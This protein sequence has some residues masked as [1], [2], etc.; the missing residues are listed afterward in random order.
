MGPKSTV[1]RRSFLG[2][3][4]SVSTRISI[5]VAF[6]AVLP[7]L[8]IGGGSLFIARYS[9]EN[10]AFS[11]I[12]DALE[13][14]HAIMKEYRSLVDLG[15]MSEQRALSFIRRL[16]LGDLVEFSIDA[17]DPAEAEAFFAELA[18]YRPAGS[19]VP[20]GIPERFS[21]RVD[22]GRA[23]LSDFLPVLHVKQGFEAMDLRAQA[24]LVNGPRAL[25]L[26][27]DLASAAVRI[28]NSGYVF[29][30]SRGRDPSLGGIYELFHPTLTMVDI[31]TVTN[32]RG[33]LVGLNISRLAGRRDSK[34]PEPYLRY[35]YLWYNQGDPGERKKITL[36]RDFEPWDLVLAAGLYEDEY[37]APLRSILTFMAAGLVL[38]GI[39]FFLLA[40]AFG[41]TLVGRR[42]EELGAAFA[43]ADAGAL[44]EFPVDWQDEFGAIARAA[45]HMARAI[46]EREAAL[47]QAQKREIAGAIAAGMAHDMNNALGGVL[48]SA[49]LLSAELEGDPDPA[50]LRTAADGVEK[51]A[52]A[53]AAQLRSMLDF[54][55]APEGDLLPLELGPVIDE[56]LAMARR[57]SPSEV[58][59]RWLTASGPAVIRG[60]RV[61][62]I[63]VF[64]NAFL[65]ARDAVTTMRRDGE[66]RGGT[67]GVS[68][69]RGSFEDGGAC[70]AVA[71]SDDGVGMSADALDRAFE[72]FY[73]SKPQGQ[74]TG[75][76]LAMIKHIARQHGGRARLSSELGA[77]TTLTIEFPAVEGDGRTERGD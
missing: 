53:A 37:F 22:G 38:S 20:Y 57:S 74:G 42:V 62:L 39:L 60:D 33:E 51:A 7:I 21:V 26:R 13:G 35:D 61:R 15:V 4:R 67:V 27:F 59:Y 50:A 58:R 63:Q 70:W 23:Y 44:Y 8:L 52:K 65:N 29:A 14:A 76:G 71:V 5:L 36:M 77:G 66:A 48:G 18:R 75:L 56:A 45:S 64:L 47:R 17:E 54:G 32:S 3:I 2:G 40:Q 30:I 69:V 46:E 41:R 1:A 12:L 6:S 49:S 25:R 16:F 72:P 68:I 43:S 19:P 34:L 28:R 55:R 11:Q 73:S 10:A 24:S 31:A 9:F